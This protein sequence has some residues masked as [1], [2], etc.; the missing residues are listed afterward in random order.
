MGLNSVSAAE[1]AGEEDGI[2]PYSSSS[3]TSGSLALSD[4]P[5]YFDLIRSVL[6]KY[7]D[8]HYYAKITPEFGSK[9]EFVSGQIIVVLFKDYFNLVV[10]QGDISFEMGMNSIQYF[11]HE[12]PQ[13]IYLPYSWRYQ[14]FVSAYSVALWFNDGELLFSDIG[15]LPDIRENREEVTYLHAQT[16]ILASF[17][18]FALFRRLWLSI[19]GRV[20]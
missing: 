12:N 10:S 11:F 17:V 19:R 8:Y 14:E 7:P 18:L 9:G 6:S 5:I 3:A 20:D 4:F 13:N 16:V 2:M 1:P 15:P